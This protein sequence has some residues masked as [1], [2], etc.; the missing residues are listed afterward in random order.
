MG[1]R[2][3]EH[4]SLEASSSV[5]CA[6]EAC[7]S[8]SSASLMPTVDDEQARE[9]IR[10]MGD[11]IRAINHA[12]TGKW[13]PPSSYGN[14][15]S[16]HALCDYLVTQNAVAITYGISSDYSFEVAIAQKL[17][18]KVVGFD[19]TVVLPSTLAPGVTFVQFGAPSPDTEPHWINISPMLVAKT[20]KV[21]RVAI[22]KMDCEGCE[23]SLYDSAIEDD[24]NFFEKVDQ[25][26]LEI[27]I[28]KFWIKTQK[29][30]LDYGKL[31]V[32]MERAGLKLAHS[33]L[34]ECAPIH[35]NYGCPQDLL[36]LNYP[37]RKGIMCQNFLFARPRQ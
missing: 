25:F 27:H 8:C 29:T 13:C 33:E 16:H 6:C 37:C 10:I 24:P 36:D 17:A 20:M 14:G 26:A 32:L 7:P 19:P 9:A 1:T 35:E 30:L 2:P 23:Y 3:K 21:D 5:V 31:L 22:L 34:T 12:D 4:A 18:I 15:G 11:R 28:S